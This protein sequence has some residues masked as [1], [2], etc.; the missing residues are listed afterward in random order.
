MV[1]RV[2]AI[3]PISIPKPKT[4]EEIPRLIEQQPLPNPTTPQ[5]N[6]T[7][8]MYEQAL[9]ALKAQQASMLGLQAQLN[10]MY[11][12]DPTAA[13]LQ[14]QMRM[15]QGDPFAAERARLNEQYRIPWRFSTAFQGMGY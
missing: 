7:Q 4:N 3:T 5:H 9:A 11:A 2:G 14:Q 13:L 1:A 10:R 6:T 15:Y 8:Q 12:T